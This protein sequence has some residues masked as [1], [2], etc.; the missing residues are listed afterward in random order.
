LAQLVLQH[1]ELLE[2]SAPCGAQAS[3]ALFVQ[4]P[5]QQSVHE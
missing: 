4:E 5:L 1:W 2:H 3:Q